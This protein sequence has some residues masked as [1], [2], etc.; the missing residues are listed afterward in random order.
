MKKQYALW[1]IQIRQIHEQWHLC[2]MCNV[3]KPIL[4]FDRH[5]TCK[6]GFDISRC[7]PCRKETS[8]KWRCTQNGYFATL[9]H[10]A[11]WNQATRYSRKGL[12]PPK[13]Q[14]TKEYLQEMYYK[15]NG[16]GFYSHIPMKLMPLSHWQLSLERLNPEKDYVPGNVVLEAYE[17]N[18]P[19]QWTLEKIL[20]IPSLIRAQK[21][22]TFDDLNAAK[23]PLRKPY[24]T[25]RK[26]LVYN[27]NCYCHDC[28]QWKSIDAFIPSRL[29]I[30]HLCR[31]RETMRYQNTFR[32]HILHMLSGARRRSRV[33]RSTVNDT[34]NEFN[35][36]SHAVFDMVK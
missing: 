23:N 26:Q 1:F 5:P 10:S 30:C 19:C 22:I 36:T 28:N 25:R 29:T 35:L 7:K 3:R 13:F 8:Y 2:G 17:F 4:D 34:R 15:Q 24:R 32:G 11:K 18:T 33:R 21:N 6:I 27:D 20:D 9:V 14:L 12:N 16:K 31:S